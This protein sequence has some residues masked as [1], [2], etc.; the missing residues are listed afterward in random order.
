MENLVNRLR[1]IR[2]LKAREARAWAG[3]RQWV[4]AQTCEK[5]KRE[6]N[7]ALA[8]MEL[9]TMRE[10]E[11]QANILLDQQQQ[12]DFQWFMERVSNNECAC[13][14][15]LGQYRRAQR[16]QQPQSPLMTNNTGPATFSSTRN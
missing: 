3:I 7:V 6:Q 13:E 15:C 14:Y 9:E 4:D 12:R 8:I 1:R 11:E 5:E 16:P 10:E 2:T